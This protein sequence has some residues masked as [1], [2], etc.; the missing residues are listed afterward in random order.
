MRIQ[1]RVARRASINGNPGKAED[2]AVWQE[3]RWE[4]PSQHQTPWSGSLPRTDLMKFLIEMFH[5][6][7]SR[8]A[9]MSSF[10]VLAPKRSSKQP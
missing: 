6:D 1:K 8:E 7:L 5:A 10:G 2:A 4:A 9:L 3:M